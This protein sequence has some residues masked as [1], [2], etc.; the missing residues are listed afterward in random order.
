MSL[1]VVLVGLSLFLENTNLLKTGPRTSEFEPM[2]GKVVKFSDVHGVDEAKEELKDVVDFL[3]DP[4]AFSALGGKL[5][6]GILLTGS[7][8]TGKTMLARAVAGEAGVPFLFA[9]GSE[10]EEI[11]VGVGAKRVRELFATA[12]KKQPAIIFIDELDAIGGK[13]NNREQQ[14]LKQTLNQLL[15]EMDGFLQSE[16][17]IVI[18]ATNFPESLDQYVKFT[19]KFDALSYSLF[20]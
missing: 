10:F 4:T 16:G 9:S 19:T 7:P 5:P 3:K 20:L 11:F 1:S 2:K 17:V 8:G 6:K 15:V 12:R 13:R 18:A 14:H